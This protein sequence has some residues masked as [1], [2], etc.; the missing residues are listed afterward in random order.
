MLQNPVSWKRL[1]SERMKSV[2]W[3]FGPF[4]TAKFGRI[5]GPGIPETRTQASLMRLYS[6]E[7]R[8]VMKT[9]RV[10]VANHPRLMRELTMATISD[11]PDITIVGEVKEESELL[12]AVE[13]TQPDFLIVALDESNRLPEKCVSILHKHPELKI[14]AIRSDRNIAM[15]YWT[16]LSVES[17]QFEASETALLSVL[18]G[19]S[20]TAPSNE[21]WT[22]RIV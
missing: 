20:Q 21:P 4:F 19:K 18:R 14:I 3:H 16:S 22:K 5:V 17:D 11:Q 7:A 10:L 2:Q 8:C 9:I 13:Q 15:F 6:A 1:L 12:S